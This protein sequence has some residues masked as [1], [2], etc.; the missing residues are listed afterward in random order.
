MK[1]P[2]CEADLNI[3]ENTAVGEIVSFSDW[4]ADYEITKKDGKTVEI[5]E[6]KTVG[7]DWGE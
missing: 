5:K 6:A 3:P 1:V 2:E 7:E 4:G